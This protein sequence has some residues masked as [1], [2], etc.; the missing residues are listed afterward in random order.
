MSTIAEHLSRVLALTSPGAAVTL[1]LQDALGCVLA[2]DARATLA[3]PPF[4]NSAMDGY[5]V[6]TVDLDSAGTAILQVSG[7]VAAGARAC[8]PA[9]GC[10][11]RIMTGA[12][13]P[14]PVPAGLAVIP[15]E[16]TSARPGPHKLPDTINIHRYR[17]RAHIR[18]RGDNLAPGD[19]VARAGELVDAGMLAGLISAGV[20]EV[21]VFPRP[22]VTVLSSGD[23]LVA[24]GVTPAEGQIPDSNRPMVAALLREA[25]VTEVS[26][27]HTGDDPGEFQET[28]T[29][30]VSGSDL[31]I[32]TGGVSAG[33]FDVVKA[34][35]GGA[36]EMW[37]GA[38][39]MQ[40][41]K[42]QGAGTWKRADGG[43]TVVLCLPGNP[44]AAFVSFLIFVH[45]VLEK[46]CGLPTVAELDS[47]PRV[48][49]TAQVVFPDAR[50]K[51][52]IIP[53][54]LSWGPGGA[55][56]APFTR[57]GRG[58]HFVASLNGVD[59]FTIVPTHGTGAAPGEPLEVYLW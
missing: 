33:A 13:L 14:D 35:I 28:F 43:D 58:S 48:T 2:T 42:P 9:P 4:S 30:A 45:P 10:A 37:F 16:D 25:G 32:T 57:Q 46:L 51:D 34:V 56:A 39:E 12:P 6:N 40:P 17:G 11:I 1:P 22:K 54:R 29:R 59:G 23:E 3:V 49:A 24:A 8:V 31:V 44:V 41:G 50:A 19:C 27:A 55:G 26:E 20:V 38:V 36:A 52:L 15:V 5:L 21:E 47:R 18:P 53:V 7:D